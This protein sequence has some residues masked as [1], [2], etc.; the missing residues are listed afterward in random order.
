MK[1]RAEE[2]RPVTSLRNSAPSCPVN[3]EIASGL[4]G[5]GRISHDK[6]DRTVNFGT[7]FKV[8]RRKNRRMGQSDSGSRFFDNSRPQLARDGANNPWKRG[9]RSMKTWQSFCTA[10][11]ACAGLTP[12]LWAQ[13]PA[14]PAA[15]GAAAPAATGLGAKLGSL[16]DKK[17]ACLDKLCTTPLGQLLNN[18][19][20]PASAMTGG[21][22]PGL[23]P[24]VPSAAELA[25]PNSEGA[26][27]QIKK[28]EAEAKARAAAV[29]YLGTVDCHWWPDAEVALSN[30][31][32]ADKNECV[33]YEA[34][35]AL[36]RGCCCTKAIV[37]SLTICVNGTEEDGNPSENSARVRMAAEFAL[38]HCLET[39]PQKIEGGEKTNGGEKKSQKAPE[40]LPEKTAQQGEASEEHIHLTAYYAKQ[41]SRPWGQV[42]EEA[43]RAMEKAS[44]TEMQTTVLPTG[45]R[46][47]ADIW[48]RASAGSEGQEAT[49]IAPP[50]M[51]VIRETPRE[52]VP[53]VH[54]EKY[55][56]LLP[57]LFR[58]M[59]EAP[60]PAPGWRPA[61]ITIEIPP[62]PVAPVAPVVPVVRTPVKEPPHRVAPQANVS[63]AE[64]LSVPK[65]LG[66]LKDSH[67][68]AQ[69]EWAADCLGEADC[70]SNAMVLPC[71]MTAARTD[72]SPNVR[73]ACI[74]AL[75]KLHAT[76]SDVLGTVRALTSDMDM[77]VQK[78]ASQALIAMGVS[79]P[80]SGIQ[81]VGGSSRTP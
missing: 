38:N 65:L 57:A 62:A 70:K 1:N 81:Q 58:D 80:V 7:F 56:G 31:L 49:P 68:S 13:V 5:W 24:V 47:L 44:G 52:V 54:T 17:A 11:A 50:P 28:S 16:H 6:T 66:V 78:E 25:K 46:S 3:H 9:K 26:A 67:I 34:A 8:S 61:T 10:L 21:V 77:N 51:P 42:I 71:L 64:W 72:A 4:A 76:G 79:K 37:K 73:I 63:D 36:G 23:C 40:K 22:I 29:K 60:K 53:A 55:G 75:V 43:R 69:R 27:A 41:Q 20:K 14:A 45:H 39:V 12:G 48:E 30:A 59:N 74:H 2:K 33:R 32:R 18:M 35:L 19:T 15:A